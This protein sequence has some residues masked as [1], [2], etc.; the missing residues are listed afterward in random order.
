[1][2]TNPIVQPKVAIVASLLIGALTLAAFLLRPDTGRQPA[3]QSG[4][5]HRDASSA[6]GPEGPR[7]TALASG[8]VAAQSQS[9]ADVAV[10][11]DAVRTSLKRD[12]LASARVLLGAEQAL[13]A[14]DPRVIALQRELQ[15]REEA[16]GHGMAVEPTVAGSVS[17]PPPAS[18]RSSRYVVRYA[19]RAERVHGASSRSR[20]RAGS[21]VEYAGSGHV[22]PTE[23]VSDPG[24]RR[25]APSVVPANPETDSTALRVVPSAA[26]TSSSSSSSS[27]SQSGAL[28]PPLTQASQNNPSAQTVQSAPSAQPDSTTTTPAPPGASTQ[29]PKTRAQVRMEVEQARADGALP[30]FGNPDPAGPGGA[31]SRISHAVVLDW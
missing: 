17:V 31:P 23:A 18:S 16:G 11:L 21:P 26:A 25:S 3:E 20:E 29:A 19:A 28:P 15:A 12:D 7:S 24:V 1:M 9:D 22:L 10:V 5:G 30:R 8:K 13:Y 14:N 4:F 27:S 2:I 6:G